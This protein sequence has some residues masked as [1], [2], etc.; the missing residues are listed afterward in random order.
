MV[1]AFLPLV[2][3]QSLDSSERLF[4]KEQTIKAMIENSTSPPHLHGRSR[5]TNH[6]RILP[7][8]K[9]EHL[10]IIYARYWPEHIIVS[11]Q[12]TRH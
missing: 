12:P 8:S 4:G 10:L 11:I 1:A 5:I 7:E 3:S 6:A 9:D 2:E